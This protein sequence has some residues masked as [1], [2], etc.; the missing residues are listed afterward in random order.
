MKKFQNQLKHQVLLKF[1][2]YNIT[3]Q[4]DYLF[5]YVKSEIKSIQNKFIRGLSKT[6]QLPKW[7]NFLSTLYKESILLRRNIGFLVFQFF[8][9][10]FQMALFCLCIGREPYDI[11]FGIVNNETN[12]SAI[13]FLN[14]SIPRNASLIYINELD[15]ITFDMV[16]LYIKIY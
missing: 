3:I 9:P 2:T 14:F 15:N 4:T 11:K 12:N 1:I 16:C 6:F 13:N 5:V 10:L 8:I 7:N